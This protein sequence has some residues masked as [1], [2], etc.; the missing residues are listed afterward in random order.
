MVRQRA[1]DRLGS[2]VDSGTERVDRRAAWRRNV[3]AGRT[4]AD[5]VRTT[6]GPKGTDTM[7]VTSEGK[8]V[9]TNDG[10]RIIDLIEI[11]HPSAGMLA[12]L[13]AEQAS[14]VGDGTTTAIV[15]AGELLDRAEKLLEQGVHPTTIAAGY[16]I[17]ADRAS[18]LLDR[19][20]SRSS[21]PMPSVS[22][23]SPTRL[24]LDGGIGI[25]E[26]LSPRCSSI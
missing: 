24:S 5:L 23:P 13:A 26:D 22:K 6:L 1:G 19:M 15:L 10:T 14:A 2:I 18:T 20:R 25:R 21:P 11:S 12:D 4:L 17:A 3:A 16:H 8:V 9:I 7:V